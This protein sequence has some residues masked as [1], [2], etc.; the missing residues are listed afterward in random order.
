VV[1]VTQLPEEERIIPLKLEERERE[2]ERRESEE[3]RDDNV[4]AT[5]SLSLI[6]VDLLSAT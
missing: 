5:F 2:R 3:N 4:P 6:M 1:A